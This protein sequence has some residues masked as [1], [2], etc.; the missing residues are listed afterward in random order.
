L[1]AALSFTVMTLGNSGFLG[2]GFGS[3]FSGA[4]ATAT[5]SGLGGGGAGL[6]FFG[7][8]ET[9]FVGAGVT[10]AVLEG[11]V[12]LLQLLSIKPAKAIDTIRAFF[13]IIRIL[14]LITK[15]YADGF[16][17]NLDLLNVLWAKPMVNEQ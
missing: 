5:V 6:T 16:L 2:S 10:V 13:N 7:A 11:T 8:L 3:G 17:V 9:V 1:L 15:N 4:G 12:F 14:P